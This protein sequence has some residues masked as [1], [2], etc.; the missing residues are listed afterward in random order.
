[1]VVDWNT[2]HHPLAIHEV[3]QKT[4]RKKHRHVAHSHFT[5]AWFR[6]SLARVTICHSLY[7]PCPNVLQTV[8]DIIGS[9]LFC[10]GC[11][12]HTI[13]KLGRQSIGLFGNLLK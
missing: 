2:T 8:V 3:K 13:L 6:A 4:T 7:K 5:P 12:P 11:G 9:A 1:M 10:S